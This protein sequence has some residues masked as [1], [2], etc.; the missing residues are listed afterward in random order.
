MRTQF[1][2]RYYRCSYCRTPLYS[3]RTDPNGEICCH[4]CYM[5]T[6][7]MMEEKPKP[8]NN[9]DVCV[10]CGSGTKQGNVCSSKCYDLMYWC[11]DGNRINPNDLIKVR[12]D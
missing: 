4:Q 2:T 9:Y 10:I 12:M 11:Q 3:Y 6:L 1:D 7:S 8:K 5:V